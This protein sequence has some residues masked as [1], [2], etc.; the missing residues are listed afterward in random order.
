[1][2]RSAQGWTVIEEEKT[3]NHLIGHCG[4][5]LLVILYE[6]SHRDPSHVS[7]CMRLGR[8]LLKQRPDPLRLVALLPPLHAKPPSAEVRRAIADAVS[9]LSGYFERGTAIVTGAGFLGAIHR[10]AVT[11]VLS[12]LSTRLPLKVTGSIREGVSFVLPENLVQGEV[13]ARFCE[14]HLHLDPSRRPRL[15]DRWRTWPPPR[16]APSRTAL[17]R[18]PD[19]SPPSINR[20]LQPP[21]SMPETSLVGQ[22]LASSCAI[23]GHRARLQKP[24]DP[25][26]PVRSLLYIE[27]QHTTPAGAPSRMTP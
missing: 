4:N 6:G 25:S 16:A 10:S 14:E 20:G 13:I 1:V 19:A 18:E 21:G 27:A 3:A 5:V 24:Y 8:R 11:A 17:A 2:K 22:N 7:T 26:M 15:P 23:F 9:Q 12:L